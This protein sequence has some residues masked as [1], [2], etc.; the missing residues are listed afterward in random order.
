M[1]REEKKRETVSCRGNRVLTCTDGSRNRRI[2]V[3]ETPSRFF[4]LTAGSLGACTAATR[5]SSAVRRRLPSSRFFSLTAGSLALAPLLPVT[6]VLFVGGCLRARRT[7]RGQAPACR[8]HGQ[9]APLRA[10]RTRRGPAPACRGHGRLAPL[11]LLYHAVK[12]SLAGMQALLT[13]MPYSSYSGFYTSSVL[14]SLVNRNT[15]SPV[16]PPPQQAMTAGLPNTT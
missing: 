8:G 15:G 1:E 7:R 11:H 16:A 5:H 3:G 12:Q 6:R 10:R 2:C 14:V 13:S 9:L 4:S